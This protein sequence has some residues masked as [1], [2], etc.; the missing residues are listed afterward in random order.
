M[1]TAEKIASVVYFVRRGDGAVKVG[2]ST[3]FPNRLYMLRIAHGDLKVEAMCPGAQEI[4]L[5][6]HHRLASERIDGEWFRGPQVEAMIVDMLAAHGAP[7]PARC[8][9]VMRVSVSLG[10]ED[11]P[12][13]VSVMATMPRENDRGIPVGVSAADALRYAL[14]MCATEQRT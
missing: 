9:S 14:K 12:H 8:A 13:L 4:E 11:I 5:A 10:D 3:Q 2:F 6:C 1:S 7:D